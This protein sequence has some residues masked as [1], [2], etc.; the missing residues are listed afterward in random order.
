[1]PQFRTGPYS[2]GSNLFHNPL[3][4]LQGIGTPPEAWRILRP[5]RSGVFLP[6]HIVEPGN[7]EKWYRCGH[8]TH[9]SKILP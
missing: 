8:S 9:D 6:R 4:V 2:P 5:A 3:L 1:M 7:L